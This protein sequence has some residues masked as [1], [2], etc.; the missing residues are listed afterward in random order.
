[1]ATTKART[2]KPAVAAASAAKPA[3]KP[4]SKV[5]SKVA[6]RAAPAKGAPTGTPAPMPAR[7]HALQRS[8]FMAAAQGEA[9]TVIY[10]HGIGNKPT[11]EVLR[12]Q[13]DKALFGRGMGERTRLA[14]WVNR[15]RYPT[16]EIA[17]CGDRDEGPT[18]NQAEQRVL[19]AL[20]VTPGSRDLGQLADA[21]AGTP[22]ESAMLHGMLGELGA[23][24]TKQTGPGARG[25]F[26]KVNEILLKLISAALLQDVHDFFFDKR[27]REAMEKSLLDRME[28]GG[29]PFVVVAHSQG[30]M[31]A[32]EVLRKLDP[33]RYDV[34]LLVTIGSPLG[35]PSVRSMFKQSIR[36]KKLPFP[37]C[38]RHWYNVADRLDPVALDGN[39]ADDIENPGQRYSNLQGADIN[40]DSPRNPHSG[41]GYLSN[42]HVRAKVREVVG[43]GF[44]QPVS[45]TVLIKDL[46][47]QMEANGSEHRHEVLIELDKLPTGE[48][49]REA[50]RTALVA[51]IRGLAGGTTRLKG[52]ALDDEIY[53]EDNLQRFVSAKLTRF[54]IESLR[55]DYQTLSFKRLW[56]DAGKRALL[57][58]SRSVIQADAAQTAYRALGQKIGWA[59]L[60]TGIAAGHPHFYQKGKRDVVVAQWDC[61]VRGK[62]KKLLRADG[63]A[64]S[65][66]DRNGH[67]THVAGVIAGQCSAPLP[68]ANEKEKVE[69]TGVAPQAQ[70]YGFKVLDDDGNGRDS[71]IIK[72]VQQVADLNDQ[73]GELMIHGMNLSLGGYFDAES[74]GCGFTPLCNEL[75]RLWRQG[76]VV[77][78]AAGNE[79]LAWL[80]QNDGESYPMNMDMT[81]GD[82]AN[83]EDAIAVGSVHKGNPHSYGVSYFSS[84]G[85]TADGRHKPDVVA[86]GE[87][88]ISAHYDFKVSDPKTWMVE[89]SGTSMAAP[90]VSGLVAGFLSVRR[91]FIGSPDRVKQIL[92]AHCTDIGRDPYMQGR[93][94]PNMIQML[95]ST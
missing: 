58:Q 31:I 63:A 5:A 92:L 25:L 80:V 51:R 10:I 56:R 50:A 66:L 65:K 32:Y 62:P 23:S 87:K 81:I 1:M 91:E 7:K 4:A 37:P 44:D 34:A 14:Y 55:N 2:R 94:I 84:R 22:A 77:V 36:K 82:P 18:I 45:N 13:W 75:R 83:L 38:V 12:C 29:G 86:P 16:P 8:D 42:L 20:G 54:E 30:S 9:K 41:S 95:A 35:L 43:V 85:P 78:L 90:H 76:V 74:Y 17:T 33:A 69:F 68:G 73:A 46:S 48:G 59:V 40:I 93:G 11:P 79:G 61:T 6:K 47:D 72:A 49:G 24:K 88:I 71:W 64:F 21:L 60:D 3:P 67:G 26:D 27:R 89:M 19:S 39:L 70:L 15:L 28:S 52:R 53:L 57:N